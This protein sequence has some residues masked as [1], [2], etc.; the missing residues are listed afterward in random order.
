MP[1]PIVE[2][3]APVTSTPAKPEAK[4]TGSRFFTKGFGKKPEEKADVKVPSI[5]PASAT[6]TGEKSRLIIG[7]GFGK[8]TG[9]DD[10]KK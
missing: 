4:R 8:A 10:K 9:S 1:L 5:P 6:P 7:P 3:S 2:D